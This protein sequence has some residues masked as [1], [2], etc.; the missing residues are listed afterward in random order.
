M[1]PEV[2]SVGLAESR[3]SAVVSCATCVRWPQ[4]PSTRVS[5]RTVAKDWN[6]AR[7]GT[8][9][10]LPGILPAPGLRATMAG[11]RL[12]IRRSSR[13]RDRPGPRVRRRRFFSDVLRN[14]AGSPA[15]LPSLLSA[16][17]RRFYAGC[18]RVTPRTSPHAGSGAFSTTAQPLPAT[19]GALPGR[20]LVSAAPMEL[21]FH[22]GR[23]AARAGGAIALGVTEDAAS[24]APELAEID[25]LTRG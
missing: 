3:L 1:S 7:M 14:R 4:P 11:A 12:E 24:R 23:L 18:Q 10:W 5:S 15:E 2:T 6:V 22:H 9:L 21:R 25:R 19:L 20:L 8:L 16:C 13:A 17:G